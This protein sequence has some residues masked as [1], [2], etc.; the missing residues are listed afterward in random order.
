MKI[1][2]ETAEKIKSACARGTSQTALARQYGVSSAYISRIKS[3]HRTGGRLPE[4]RPKTILRRLYADLLASIDMGSVPDVR[5]RLCA[6]A[7][8]RIDVLL[9]KNQK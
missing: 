1:T 8:A 2:H 6:E 9:E 5:Q 4:E 3:G 7:L